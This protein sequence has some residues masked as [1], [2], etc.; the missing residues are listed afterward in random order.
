MKP[1]IDDIIKMLQNKPEV[2]TSEE[3][4]D[5]IGLYT[6]AGIKKY[7][8]SKGYS[9]DMVDQAMYQ[10]QNDKVL[11][12]KHIKIYNKRYKKDY[13]YFYR[14]LSEKE[15]QSLTEQYILV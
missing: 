5:E 10:L 14:D 2:K 3:W 9:N 15:I 11:N 6:F 4:P 8:R 7:M 12:L 13:P 1:L